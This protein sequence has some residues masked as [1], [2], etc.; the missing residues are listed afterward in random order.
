LLIVQPIVTDIELSATDLAAFE[1]D[2]AG[3]LAIDSYTQDILFRQARTPRAFTDTP[4]SDATMRAVHDLIKW[5]PTG[6]NGQPLRIALVRSPEARERLAHHM[7]A[8]NQGRTIS[9][10]LVALLAV[11][12]DFHEELDKISPAVARA[13]DAYA[14]EDRRVRAASTSALLQ[15]GYFIVGARAAGLAVGPMEGF[16]AAAVDR[17]FFPDGRHRTL[18]VVT[19]GY[20]APDAYKPRQPRLDYDEVVTTV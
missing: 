20:P 15:I 18:L 10:P 2:L 11:D 4:V 5:G 9:A 19:L 14:D 16:D 17:E 12:V 1:N 6:R 7:S 3:A 8:G 13:R